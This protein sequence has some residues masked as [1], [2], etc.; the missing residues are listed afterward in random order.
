[1]IDISSEKVVN[2]CN[3]LIA[4][5]ILDI[6]LSYIPQLTI[7]AVSLTNKYFVPE[8]SSWPDF[9]FYSVEECCTLPTAA[10]SDCRHGV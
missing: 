7:A 6:V 3:I 4:C 10:S 2:Y 8:V 9:S 1:M 5:N